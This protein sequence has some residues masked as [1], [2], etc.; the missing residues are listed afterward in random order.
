MKILHELSWLWETLG[1][2]SKHHEAEY[3]HSDYFA[4]INMVTLFANAVDGKVEGS[5]AL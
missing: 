4:A 1:L 5:L 2:I 3:E